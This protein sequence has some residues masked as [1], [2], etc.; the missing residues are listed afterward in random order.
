MARATETEVK[1]IIQTSLT[2]E[3]VTPFL[4]TA[5]V[6]VTDTLSSE[7][8][9]TDTMKQIELWLAAHFLAIRDPRRARRKIG[10]GDDTYQGKTGFGLNHTSY[11][12]QVMLLDHHGV[13]AAIASSKRPAK[14]EVI[15]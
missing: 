12:Q 1:Q 13:L 6:V 5:N 4:R 10:G 8:Y 15:L 14:V 3:E 11:G 7:G 2:L 9:G